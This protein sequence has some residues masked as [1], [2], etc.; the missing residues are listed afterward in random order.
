MKHFLLFYD[1]VPDYLARRGEFRDAHVALTA[2]AIGR[3]ELVLGGAYAD[4]AD[5][6]ALL[7]LG[8]TADVAEKFAR[9]DPYVLNG[10]VTRWQVREWTTVVG[11][12]AAQ[13]I[14][15]PKPLAAPA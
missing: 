11:R 5:G 10:L 2:E 1:Y 4:P 9:V 7:F 3:G 8:E 6:A 14:G 13:P 15:P 12:D